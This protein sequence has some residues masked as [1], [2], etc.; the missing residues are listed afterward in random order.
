MPR[1]RKG[2]HIYRRSDGR[3][4]WYAYVDRDDKSHALDT[5][6]ETEAARRLADL[7][8]RRGV[9][10]TGARAT[11]LSIAFDTCHAR[12]VTNHTEK[13]A[14][15]LSLN[16]R[17]VLAWLER[18][19]PPTLLAEDLTK[20]IVEEYKATRAATVSE[21]RI[22]REL[23]SWRKAT[24]VAVENGA[25]ADL[26]DLFEK[27]REPRPKP[28]QRRLSKRE[29]ACFFKHVDPRYRDMLRTV[30]GSGIRDEE[31]RHL[32]IDD[33]VEERRAR[34]LTVT[35]KD[36]WSTK[37]YHYRRIPITEAT[38]RAARAFLAAKPPMDKRWVWE[39]IQR[40]CAA[41]ELE[42]F[43]MHDLRKA[44][45]TG[46]IDA[47]NSLQAVSRWLG[48]R[49]IITTMRYLGITD[50]RMPPARRLPW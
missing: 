24:K 48:H 32:E 38:L 42:A 20:A 21:A 15:E 2:P 6:D 14:Y 27:M 35:P 36:G 29:L 3:P 37:S 16:L 22:N 28:H 40:A 45:A 49:D 30:L 34:W 9:R 10:A 17:R 50:E 39:V 43:S 23:D 8:Q 26:L 46:M 1:P 41:A 25:P 11:P 33:L 13:T 47:G 4:G 12:A 19:D 7:L 31:M 5:E 44:W 18:H